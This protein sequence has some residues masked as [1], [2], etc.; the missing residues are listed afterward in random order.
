MSI[1][2]RSR[3]FQSSI[4]V[5]FFLFD[6]P[7][8]LECATHMPRSISQSDNISL[9]PPSHLP[10]TKRVIDTWNESELC[11]IENCHGSRAI[12]SAS[13]LACLFSPSRSPM[14]LPLGAPPYAETGKRKNRNQMQVPD[15]ACNYMRPEALVHLESR[16]WIILMEAHGPVCSCGGNSRDMERHGLDGNT[17]WVAHHLSGRSCQFIVGSILTR[18]SRKSSRP[19]LKKTNTLWLESVIWLYHQ[20]G[21]G[22]SKWACT[23]HTGSV[24]FD[25]T[26]QLYL[27]PTA[28]SNLSRNHI[29]FPRVRMCP[30]SQST[31]LLHAPIRKLPSRSRLGSVSAAIAVAEQKAPLPATLT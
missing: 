18:F 11:H 31:Q 20:F 10:I 6:G 22:A 8:I 3:D 21:K 30:M 26:S 17:L 9:S 2:I 12:H 1:A 28:V 23:P 24:R 19:L 16:K 15:S 13:T 25:L 27:I 29:N 4:L 7:A 14:G 5:R